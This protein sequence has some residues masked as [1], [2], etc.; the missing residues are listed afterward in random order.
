VT[1]TPSRFAFTI[2]TQQVLGYSPV[3]FG[4]AAATVALTSLVGIAVGQHLITRIGVRPAAALGLTLVVVSSLGLSAATRDPTTT[5]IVLAVLAAF[6][7]GMGAVFV[8]GQVAALAGIAPED[9]GLASGIEETTFAVAGAL[10]V[11]V[12]SGVILAYGARAAFL[13]VPVF[14]TIGL[15]AVTFVLPAAVGMQVADRPRSRD[16]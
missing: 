10:G 9:A 6:G 5:G 2:F 15:V 12:V 3:R 13:A 4:L 14:A 7:P 8:A 16:R 11:A 1:S